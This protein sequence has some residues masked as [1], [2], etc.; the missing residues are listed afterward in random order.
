MR[1][2]NIKSCLTWGEGSWVSDRHT[3]YSK[4]TGHIVFLELDDRYSFYLY[5]LNCIWKLY[6]VFCMCGIFHNLKKLKIVQKLDYK[7]DRGKTP[8]KPLHMEEF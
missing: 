8:K 1:I 7:W 5:S 4:C 3:G 2:V 6:T